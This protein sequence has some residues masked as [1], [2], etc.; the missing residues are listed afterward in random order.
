[1]KRSLKN[2]EPELFIKLF[3]SFL[4]QIPLKLR[5]FVAQYENYY[6]TI[7]YCII[8][9]L[10]LD[11]DAEYATSEG[12]VDI[13]I[14]TTEYIYV[15]ELKINGTAEDAIQQIEKRHYCRPFE[16]DPRRMYKIGLGFSKQTNTIESSII[17]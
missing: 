7:F 3:S 4:A 2:G 8:T 10:G 1:M 15:I 6:H 17:L 12:Y 16:S 9:L 5:T 11:I 13:L 14:K